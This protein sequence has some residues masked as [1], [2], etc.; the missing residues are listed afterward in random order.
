MI[1]I[2][3]E[4]YAGKNDEN[5]ALE[6]RD[7]VNFQFRLSPKQELCRW[8]LWVERDSYA[9]LICSEEI[10]LVMAPAKPAD[11]LAFEYNGNQK[12]L[13]NE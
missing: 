3:M 4:I 6:I 5:Y 1:S 12:P 7:G 8:D 2:Y 9:L 10:F 13:M 11:L